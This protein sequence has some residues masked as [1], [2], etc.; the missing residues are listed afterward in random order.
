MAE[1]GEVQEVEGDAQAPPEPSD[2]AEAP[3]VQQSGGLSWCVL[4]EEAGRGGGVRADSGD[5]TVEPPEPGDNAEAVLQSGGLSW[6][7]LRDKEVRVGDVTKPA[8]PRSPT[9]VTTPVA[10][11]RTQAQAVHAT[12]DA[13]MFGKSIAAQVL[14]SVGAKPRYEELHGRRPRGL[15]VP[16][17]LKPEPIGG[18][19]WNQGGNLM[20]SQC[21]SPRHVYGHVIPHTRRSWVDSVPEPGVLAAQGP[22]LEASGLSPRRTRLHQPRHKQLGSPRLS[23]VAAASPRSSFARTLGVFRAENLASRKERLPA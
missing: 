4:R 12:R 10:Y 20:P 2:D 9:D 7:V 18:D 14:G 17:W 19:N 22:G 6:R 5:V 11:P 1:V 23:Y 8:D 15:D 13:T 16:R 21:M 3:A